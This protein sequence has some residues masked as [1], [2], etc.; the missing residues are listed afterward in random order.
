MMTPLRQNPGVGKGRKRTGNQSPQGSLG[1]PFVLHKEGPSK[2]SVP[3][4]GHS[5]APLSLLNKDSLERHQQKCRRVERRA[6]L[7]MKERERSGIPESLMQAS[8]TPWISAKTVEPGIDALLKLPPDCLSCPEQET[9]KCN[10]IQ[11]KYN[12]MPKD[13]NQ[14]HQTG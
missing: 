9:I 2:A 1:K 14:E 7:T 12:G 6:L 5:M 10:E 3:P 11:I 13:Y 8:M 4:V